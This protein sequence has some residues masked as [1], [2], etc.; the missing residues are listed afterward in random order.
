MQLIFDR[1]LATQRAIEV[2]FFG[3]SLMRNV[4]NGSWSRALSAVEAVPD[5]GTLTANPSFTTVEA[6][7]G[8]VNVPLQGSYNTV[9]DANANYNAATG[10][11][12]ITVVLGW[13]EA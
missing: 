13:R 8:A 4:L 3:E 12:A 6:V 1:D 2:D 11:Y 7:N 10:V 5:L 9:V